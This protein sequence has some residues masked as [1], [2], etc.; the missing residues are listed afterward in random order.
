MQSVYQVSIGTIGIR[1]E[2]VQKNCYVCMFFFSSQHCHLTSHIFPLFSIHISFQL[3]LC[4]Q[5]F[6]N[7]EYCTTMTP[8]KQLQNIYITLLLSFFFFSYL[9]LQNYTSYWGQPDLRNCTG[10]CMH[11]NL[12]LKYQFCVLC[13]L[14]SIRKLH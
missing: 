2:S 10:K 12:W 6:V 9:G 3:G 7:R 5:E 1:W 11:I 14:P 4:C 13:F 8:T